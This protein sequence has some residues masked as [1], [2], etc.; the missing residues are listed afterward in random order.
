MQMLIEYMKSNYERKLFK[1][2]H[3]KFTIVNF[4]I[5]TT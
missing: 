1:G 5:L 2:W 4:T 3:S